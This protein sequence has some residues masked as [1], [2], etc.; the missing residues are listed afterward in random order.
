MTS[1][2]K[3]LLTKEL[4]KASAALHQA[5]TLATQCGKFDLSR[6]LRQQQ[7]AVADEITKLNGGPVKLT[8]A[9]LLS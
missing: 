5:F 2:Q 4:S 8:G 7:Q 9:E 1:I 3:A 6:N